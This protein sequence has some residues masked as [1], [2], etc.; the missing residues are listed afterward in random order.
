MGARITQRIYICD[1]CGKTPEDGE[2]LWTMCNKVICE[3][4]I[5]KQEEEDN[6]E[7]LNKETEIT[8]KE[9]WYV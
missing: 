6:K 4:C 2:H 9:V 3:D 1:V 5:K 8:N 7:E